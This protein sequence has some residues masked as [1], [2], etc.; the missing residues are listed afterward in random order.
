MARAL[1][2]EQALH[3]RERV[4]R[5]HADRL[6][7][8]DPAMDVALVAPRLVV[9]GGLACGARGVSPRGAASEEIFF[10]GSFESPI[11]GS[12]RLLAVVTIIRFTL[13]NLAN[14]VR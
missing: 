6:V 3:D 8:H 9:F 4:G 10:S 12:I 11:G 14:L 2:L 5:G 1:G 13:P 7:E